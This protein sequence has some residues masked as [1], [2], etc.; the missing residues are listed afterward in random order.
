ML[1]GWSGRL[2]RLKKELAELMAASLSSG[3]AFECLATTAPWAWRRTDCAVASTANRRAAL[4]QIGRANA[5]QK[6]ITLITHARLGCYRLERKLPGG[7]DALPLEFC[8]FPPIRSLFGQR[9]RQ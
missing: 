3:A 8:A 4:I 7:F 9:K 6:A 5:L 1:G 2:K